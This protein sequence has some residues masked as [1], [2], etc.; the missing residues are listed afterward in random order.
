MALARILQSEWTCNTKVAIF[1]L[2]L[3]SEITITVFGSEREFLKILSRL[4]MW[5]L[6]I[7]VLYEDYQKKGKSHWDNY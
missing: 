3:A 2:M 5:A 7:K 6:L 4:Y 1:F